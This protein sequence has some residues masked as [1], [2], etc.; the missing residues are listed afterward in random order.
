MSPRKLVL[1][2]TL[3]VPALAVSAMVIWEVAKPDAAVVLPD[4]PNG[5]SSH[6]AAGIPIWIVRQDSMVD[7][8]VNRSPHHGEQLVWCVEEEVFSPSKPGRSSTGE[9]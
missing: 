1:V 5:V 8:F 6:H 4:V 2:L 9:E 7:A 3:G